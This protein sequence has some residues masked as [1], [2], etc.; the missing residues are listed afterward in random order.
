MRD[1]IK[2]LAGFVI[3]LAISYFH[4][5]GLIVGGLA[6]GAVTRSLKVALVSGFIFGIVVWLAFV[7]MLSVNGM[8]GKFFAMSPLQYI[9]LVLT[10]IATTISASITNFFSRSSQYKT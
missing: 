7:A 5:V 4:W 10:V 3:G 9:S 2:L 8:V 1:E 6:V